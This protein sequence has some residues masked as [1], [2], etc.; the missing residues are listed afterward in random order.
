[1]KRLHGA[2]LDFRVGLHQATEVIRI[3][4]QDH[5]SASLNDVGHDQSVDRCR[6]LRLTEKPTGASCDRRRGIGDVS[7]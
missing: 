5:P 7:C 3:A 6:R 1:M 4:G 2:D